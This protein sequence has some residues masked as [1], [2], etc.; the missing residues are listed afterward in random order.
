MSPQH[1]NRSAL[2]EGTLRCLERLP[3]ERITARAIAEES[4]ANLASIGYHFGSK[5]ELV[6]EAAIEGLDRWLE[7]MEG[8]LGD[9]A[10]APPEDRL[11][12]AT[13]VMKVSR[14][15]HTGLARNYLAALAKGQHDPRIKKALADGFR[16]ARPSVAALLGLGDDRAGQDAAGIALS[17]FHGLLIQALLDPELAI[18]GKQME[19]A[20]ARLGTVMP[21]SGD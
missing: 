4:G 11:Q 7:E 2:L 8:A 13:A 12:R 3:P 21:D 19:R 20:L 18:E 14:G 15:D 10:S 17:L 1:S 16:D 9:L 6:S 5:E